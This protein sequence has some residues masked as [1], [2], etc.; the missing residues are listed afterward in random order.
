M[1]EPLILAQLSDPH[2]GAE[3]GGRDPV[4]RLRAAVARV[5]GLPDE[6][7][8]VLVSGDLTND[9][10]AEQY[11]TV[12]AELSRLEAPVHVLA[13]NHDSR[14]LLRAAFDLEGAAEAPV[15]YA[16][17][18]GPL[19]LLVADTTVPGEDRGRIDAAWLRRL[20]AALAAAPETPTILAMHH[21]PLA[22]GIPAWDEINLTL[23]ERAALGEVVARQGQLLAIAGGHL[24]RGVSG[25][26]GGVPVLA[27]PSV[28]V[29]VAPEF[30]AE[31]P[32][33]GNEDPP[34]FALH[35]FRDDEL[36]SQVVSYPA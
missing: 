11:A 13:G 1:A 27:V 15:E 4:E 21:P 5:N 23:P 22:T 30:G 2:I 16:V 34:A 31:S 28:Y 6:V 9:G 25:A 29:Q 17:D 19:R 26:L 12:R 8:A 20:E 35:V 3:W 10:D 36:S 33:Q 32:P 24:H 14:A 18:L 7:D